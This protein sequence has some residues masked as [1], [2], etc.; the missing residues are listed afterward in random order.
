MD[1]AALFIGF[2]VGFVLSVIAKKFKNTLDAS[3]FGIPSPLHPPL[4][5]QPIGIQNEFPAGVIR[6]EAGFI[7]SIKTE[8]SKEWIVFFSPCDDV[9][10]SQHLQVGNYSTSIREILEKDIAKRNEAKQI[11]AKEPKMEVVDVVAVGGAID[12]LEI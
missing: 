12:Q 6:D 2:A 9:I 10:A 7:Q 1:A 4:P 5:S 8:D 11:E 3:P